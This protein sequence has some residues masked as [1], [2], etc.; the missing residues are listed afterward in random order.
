MFQIQ[1]SNTICD[2]TKKKKR[3]R[4][5]PDCRRP[6]TISMI[7]T[8]TASI[9]PRRFPASKSGLGK[10][11]SANE[12]QSP[13]P[14]YCFPSSQA[15]FL[16]GVEKNKKQSKSSLFIAKKNMN[17][18]PTMEEKTDR[19]DK[20]VRNIFDVGNKNSSHADN[21]ASLSKKSSTD[22]LTSAK[23]VTSRSNEVNE[24][25]VQNGKKLDSSNLRNGL[26][27]NTDPLSRWL[28]DINLKACDLLG[29]TTNTLDVSND[30]QSP[31]LNGNASFMKS[32]EG[33]TATQSDSLVNNSFTNVVPKL[34]RMKLYSSRNARRQNFY[35]PRPDLNKVDCSDDEKEDD[36]VGN[37]DRGVSHWS[38]NL[39]SDNSTSSPSVSFS[40][41]CGHDCA[42]IM[43]SMKRNNRK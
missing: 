1:G 12:N 21:Y 35:T 13:D 3:T 2:K 37:H 10:S 42:N 24:D 36:G 23:I 34:P 17:F 29:L 6:S 31:V 16:D 19:N 25:R 27:V 8:I 9:S 43:V 28:F 11:S 18:R 20:L 7:S 26:A 14:V 32:L 40:F 4:K 30:H 22:E 41:F 38:R 33:Q 15:L 39:V 5:I